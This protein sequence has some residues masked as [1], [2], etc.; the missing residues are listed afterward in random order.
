MNVLKLCFAFS[1]LRS[2]GAYVSIWW[3]RAAW[4]AILFLNMGRWPALFLA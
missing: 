3:A 1:L 2:F 4:V